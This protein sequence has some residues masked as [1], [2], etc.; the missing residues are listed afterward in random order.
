MTAVTGVC[1]GRLGWLHNRF[2]VVAETCVMAC[3][4]QLGL[5]CMMMRLNMTG[6]NN[7]G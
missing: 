2:C 3:D 6:M 7:R 5:Y 4:S 1:F